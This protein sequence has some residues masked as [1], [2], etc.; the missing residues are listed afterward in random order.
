MSFLDLEKGFYA[1]P[2]HKV[3]QILSDRRISSEILRLT[4]KMYENANIKNITISQTFTT[5]T[6]LR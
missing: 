4:R 2:R 1:A 5:S 3:W 6:G